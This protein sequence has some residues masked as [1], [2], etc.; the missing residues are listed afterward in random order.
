MEGLSKY[1]LM[2]V[3]VCVC[4]CMRDSIHPIWIKL[5]PHMYSFI[6]W[7][8]VSEGGRQPYWYNWFELIVF[9]LLD[10]LP[11]QSSRAQSALL[12]YNSGKIVGFILFLRV[13]ALHEM[14][15]DTSWIWTWVTES[16][17]HDDNPYTMSV[18]VYFCMT[19]GD[20]KFISRI[21]FED[22]EDIKWNMMELL[23]MI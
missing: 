18:F 4:V 10:W 12:F 6:S 8:L 20:C 1:I 7:G 15:T 21:R 16:I 19:N 14:Q 11:Y 9:L 17:S 5:P 13:L 3:C 23:Y 2:C 22:L